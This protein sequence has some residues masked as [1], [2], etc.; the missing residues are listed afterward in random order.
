MTGYHVGSVANVALRVFFR[1]VTGFHRTAGYA[2]RFQ[3][4]P[5]NPLYISYAP[6]LASHLPG[7]RFRPG[8][9]IPEMIFS[10]GPGLIPAFSAKGKLSLTAA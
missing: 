6:K 3:S 10:Y 7:V 9:A 1:G 4:A 5:S 8:M 2:T